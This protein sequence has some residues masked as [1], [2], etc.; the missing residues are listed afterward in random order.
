MFKEGITEYFLKPDMVIVENGLGMGKVNIRPLIDPKDEGQ[1]NHVGL[2]HRT[3]LPASNVRFSLLYNDIHSCF[4]SAGSCGF[5][6]SFFHKL[7]VRTQ[8]IKYNIEAG[9][10]AA[11]A[12]LDK[13]IEFRYIPLT[14]LK[15]GKK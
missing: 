1:I 8:D 12:M 9:F 5:Y 3:G 6:P 7:R 11:M 15:I 2:D 4:Y 13:R 14:N 10:F